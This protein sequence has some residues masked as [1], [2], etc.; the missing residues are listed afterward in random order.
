V[1]TDVRSNREGN[2][3]VGYARPRT[4]LYTRRRVYPKTGGARAFTILG[5]NVILT[6]A[7]AGNKKSSSTRN[8]PLKLRGTRRRHRPGF[9]QSGG[10]LVSAEGNANA[11]G[12]IY[13]D[14]RTS[15]PLLPNGETSGRGVRATDADGP[16]VLHVY[17]N[18]SLFYRIAKTRRD[19]LPLRE[20]NTVRNNA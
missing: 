6:L 2:R 19:W 10:T 13:L 16:S 15:P 11:P 5:L 17:R 7:Y 8:G 3:F 1:K 18:D 9:E 20:S 4:R 12:T 14:T